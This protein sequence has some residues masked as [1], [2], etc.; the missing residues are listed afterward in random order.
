MYETALAAG[1]PIVSTETCAI[2]CTMLLVW[3]N[4]DLPPQ[5]ATQAKGAAKTAPSF[6]YTIQHTA[7]VQKTSKY[8][9]EKYFL[10]KYAEIYAYNTRWR[11]DKYPF[12]RY[13]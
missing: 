5:N 3:G 4:T 13:S 1:L 12:R 2:L 11:L 7:P 9:E 8:L 6:F 10:C